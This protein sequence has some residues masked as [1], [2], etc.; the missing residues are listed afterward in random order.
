MARQSGLPGPSALRGGGDL[1]GTISLPVNAR[2]VL[3]VREE[4]D[5]FLLIIGPCHEPFV[6]ND[7]FRL[8]RDILLDFCRFLIIV[9]AILICEAGIS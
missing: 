1:L 3:H 7:S 4:Y 6:E 8:E 9:C 5:V 2:A